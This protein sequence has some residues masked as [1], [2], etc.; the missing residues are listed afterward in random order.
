[1]SWDPENAGGGQIL[2]GIIMERIFYI[3]LKYIFSL[4]EILQTS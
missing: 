3:Y 2:I 1:M 4:L